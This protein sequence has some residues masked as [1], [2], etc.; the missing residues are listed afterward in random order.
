MSSKIALVLGFAA[1]STIALGCGDSGSGRSG[2]DEVPGDPNAAWVQL[3]EM[4]F[5]E[6]I[7]G[8]VSFATPWGDLANGP[9]AT[10]ARVSAGMGIPPHLH[11]SDISSVVFEAPMEIPAPSNE[12]EPGSLTLGSYMFVPGANQHAMNCTNDTDDCLFL[13]QQDAGFDFVQTDPPAGDPPIDRNPNAV[14]KKFENIEFVELIPDVLDFGPLSGDFMTEAHTTIARIKAGTGIPPHW[15]TLEVR[16]FVLQGMVEVP[17]PF[18]QTNPIT[19][20]LGAYFLVPAEAEHAM[21]CLSDSVD[22]MLLIVQD[23]AFDVTFLDM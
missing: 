23:G 10:F 6:I 16:G 7:P 18:D 3:S 1:V 8:I 4:S 2:N 14:M 22:C 17:I 15:H 21:N 5:E 19:M 13:I 9:H 20:T 11:S 12:S